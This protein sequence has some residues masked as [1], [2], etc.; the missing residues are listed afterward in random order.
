[1]AKKE[2]IGYKPID[3]AYT[4]DIDAWFIILLLIVFFPVGLYLMWTRTSWP[5]WLKA[6]V[7]SLCV[8]LFFVKLVSTSLNSNAATASGAETTAAAVTAVTES[9][10]SL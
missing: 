5:K 6:T 4:K 7:T 1:M 2:R 9:R 3:N 10:I 8:A